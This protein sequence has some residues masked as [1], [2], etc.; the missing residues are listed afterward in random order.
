M[1]SIYDYLQ[2]TNLPLNREVGF[3]INKSNSPF[4]NDSGIDYDYRGFYNKYNTLQPTAT[5]GH[6]TDEF[7]KLIH[8]TFSIESNYYNKEPYA[9]DWRKDPYKTLSEMGIL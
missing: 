4:A 9:I 8:P 1:N 2:T 3:Y 5:N 6:L 7:K